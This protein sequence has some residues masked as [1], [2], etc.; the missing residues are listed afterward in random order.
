M[1][2]RIDLTPQAR[3]DFKRIGNVEAQRILKFLRKRIQDSD[4][5]RSMG[6]ALAGVEL[7]GL[8]RYRVGDYRIL[9]RIEDEILCV[10]VVKIGHRR[11]VYK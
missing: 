1:T 9:C 4:D 11:E 5:P 8:W 10:L 6:K 2:W 3:S 7:G